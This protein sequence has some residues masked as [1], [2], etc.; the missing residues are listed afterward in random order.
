LDNAAMGARLDN[1]TVL[2]ADASTTD[3]YV[4]AVPA[5]VIVAC[6]IFGN[7]THEDIART[8]AH[9]PMLAA[10]RASVIWTRHRHSRDATP[11]IRETFAANGFDEHA[12]ELTPAFGV[13]LHRLAAD[14]VPLET[15]VRMFDFLGYDVLEPE[16]HAAQVRN[17]G[18]EAG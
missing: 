9:L 6:G 11:Y 4:G 18:R 14:P 15:G 7:I 2:T 13:G 12:F 1:I 8:I 17:Q 5:D 16:F 10:R 3:A